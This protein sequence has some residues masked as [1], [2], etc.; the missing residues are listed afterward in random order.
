LSEDNVLEQR[1]LREWRLANGPGKEV[2]F[3]QTDSNL[4]YHS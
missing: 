1:R 2:F 4:G 3:S